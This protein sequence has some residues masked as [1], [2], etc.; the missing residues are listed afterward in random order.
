MP[1]GLFVIGAFTGLLGAYALDQAMDDMSGCGCPPGGPPRVPPAT[2]ETIEQLK[3]EFPAAVTEVIT[4]VRAQDP[5]ALVNWQKM[6]GYLPGLTEAVAMYYTMLDPAVPLTPRLQI[7]AALAYGIF[8]FD[9]VPDGVPVVGYLDD[10]GVIV[11]AFKLASA[12]ITPEHKAQ[13]M[14][15]LKSK[16]VEPTPLVDMGT[17]DMV[18]GAFRTHSNRALPGSV[19]PPAPPKTWK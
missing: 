6:T 19:Q 2:K 1:A 15:W 10:V 7:A 4:E 12:H 9:L 13:A 17:L 5:S 3:H 18:L 16:G 8:P 11:E 14:Q